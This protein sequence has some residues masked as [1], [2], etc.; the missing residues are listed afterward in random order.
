MRKISLI[1]IIAL[2]S[3]FSVVSETAEAS[4]PMLAYKNVQLN[5]IDSISSVT[6]TY[7]NLQINPGQEF[8]ITLAESGSN[9]VLSNAFTINLITNRK[10]PVFVN[11]SF[12]PLINV[13]DSSSR[14][15]VVYTLSSST[16]PNPL[17]AGVTTGQSYWGGFYSTDTKYQYFSSF[18]LLDSSSSLNVS[19]TDWTDASLRYHIT[20]VESQGSW[21]IIGVTYW[22][23]EWEEADMIITDS[24]TLPLLTSGQVIKAE[25]TFNLSISKSDYS[26]LIANQDYAA[27]VKLS[28]SVE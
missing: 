26:K 7:N 11:L 23:G 3:L 27:V 15:P 13:Q 21:K 20:K 24:N 1:L 6:V 12:S 5:E 25:A 18:T 19:T 4:L 9:L 10:N 2:L 28:V 16:S 8:E 17:E 22:S 14:I